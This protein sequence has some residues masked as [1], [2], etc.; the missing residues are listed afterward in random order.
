MSDPPPHAAAKDSVLGSWIGEYFADRVLG[1]G[2]MGKVYRATGRDGSRVALKV[3]KKQYAQHESF[4]RRFYRE[5]RVAQ[6]V[7]HP[8]VVPVFS[9][10]EHLGLPYMVQGYVDGPSL[11]ETL[12][13]DGP[14][15]VARSMRI[16]RDVAGGLDAL[17]GAGMI[18]RDIKPGNVLLDRHGRAY[19][20]DFGLA[21][22]P[23]GSVLT[24]PGRA[25]GSADYMAPEQIRGEPVSAATDIYALG[26]MIYECL[27][28]RPPFSGV[29]GM[30]LM[31]AH[32]HDAP[33]DPERLR[34]D[35][36]AGFGSTLLLALEKDWHRRPTTAGEYAR[37]LANSAHL[38][39]DATG[40]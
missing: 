2:G 11:A 9:L 36:P 22:D 40:S 19:V 24:L 8:N 13:R 26:C 5:A 15:D 39:L 38:D 29:A 7:K 20:T 1:E 3:V 34:G 12:R 17:Q 4:R 32:L 14:L 18:H 25:I 33:P 21:K 6:T 10:G 16:C 23:H 30:R 28:G 35:L 27:C 31:W 37:M